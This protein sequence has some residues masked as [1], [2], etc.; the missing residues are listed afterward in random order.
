MAAFSLYP[1]YG[2]PQITMSS[3]IFEVSRGFTVPNGCEIQ[4]LAAYTYTVTHMP[5]IV[6]TSATIFP[7]VSRFNWFNKNIC[8][9]L[10]TPNI[11]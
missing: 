6:Y 11:R 9:L 5:G 1:S 10:F 7:V 3:F 8:H 4:R 2:K